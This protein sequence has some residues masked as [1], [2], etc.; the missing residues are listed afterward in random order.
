MR[1]L[2]VEIHR[3]TVSTD[4]FH[5]K[6][7]IE[8]LFDFYS[9]PLLLCDV[10]ACG[11]ATL[12]KS[13]D[14][15]S[16]HRWGEKR[17]WGRLQDTEG[18]RRGE[19]CSTLGSGW[20]GARWDHGVGGPLTRRRHTRPWP[21]IRTH[22]YNLYNLYNLYSSYNLYNLYSR[23]TCTAFIA[24]TTYTIC[25][26]CTTADRLPPG[27]TAA[28]QSHPINASAGFDWR[29]DTA[30]PKPSGTY[31]FHIL[32]IKRKVYVRHFSLKAHHQRVF[33]YRIK[34]GKGRIREICREEKVNQ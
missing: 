28:G 20:L 22:L 27:E 32:R 17:R 12:A 19:W 23:T 6:S 4:G 11:S 3:S 10:L 7:I 33:I 31:S 29:F 2:K 30:D 18:Q 16:S 25:T 21:P 9:A 5:W 14:A 34:A 15:S 26:T 13:P 24:C 8:Q 1:P